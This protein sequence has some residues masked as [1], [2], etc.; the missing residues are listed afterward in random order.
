[1]VHG[2][3]LNYFDFVYPDPYNF[4]RR[5]SFE[6]TN[7]MQR[8]SPSR[9]INMD[10]RCKCYWKEAGDEKWIGTGGFRRIEFSHSLIIL[11]TL[12]VSLCTRRPVD[13]CLACCFTSIHF[14]SGSLNERTV[15]D[16][17][18]LFR[19]ILCSFR[20]TLFIRA[21]STSLVRARTERNLCEIARIICTFLAFH[22]ANLGL[23]LYC[24]RAIN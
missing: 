10:R 9:E 19:A 23:R 17:Y 24:N 20:S 1:M 8:T 7:R 14:G 18:T 11:S 16:G 12:G 21:L 13:T 3:S 22:R 2:V 4:E 15:Q 5:V 6:K